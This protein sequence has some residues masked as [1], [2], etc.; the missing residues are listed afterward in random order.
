[1]DS[2]I[3]V[4]AFSSQVEKRGWL[5]KATKGLSGGSGEP[6]SAEIALIALSM[7]SF[8]N[9]QMLRASLAM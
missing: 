7:L 8:Q 2:V 3:S 5:E 1:M 4:E 6:R 9:P